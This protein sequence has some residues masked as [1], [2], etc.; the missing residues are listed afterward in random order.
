MSLLG[1][2]TGLF[3][4]RDVWSMVKCLRQA[5][6]ERAPPPPRP[7]D[8]GHGGRYYAPSPSP[9]PFPTLFV[10]ASVF[11]VV[12]QLF[13]THPYPTPS[14]LPSFFDPLCGI[15][16]YKGRPCGTAKHEGKICLHTHIVALAVLGRV[17]GG[18]GPANSDDDDTGGGGVDPGGEE[19]GTGKGEWK[20]NKSLFMTKVN[21]LLKIWGAVKFPVNPIPHLSQA[22]KRGLLREGSVLSCLED[23][24]E[25]CDGPFQTLRNVNATALVPVRKVFC[26]RVLLLWCWSSR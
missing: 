16:A 21:Q 17:C 6:N 5:T 11:D 10:S 19:M 24:C 23:V 12:L 15:Q 25:V 7:H 1:V 2:G 22:G 18:T 4:E 26:C 8:D 13:L 14:L 3:L 20:R 9:A